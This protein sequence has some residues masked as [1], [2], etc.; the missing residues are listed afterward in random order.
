[1]E[2]MLRANKLFIEGILL[3]LN[4]KELKDAKKTPFPFI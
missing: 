3:I 1:M 2:S 4:E